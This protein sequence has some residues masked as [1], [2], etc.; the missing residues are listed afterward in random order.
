MVR[1][2]FEVND[3]TAKKWRYANPEIKQFIEK[4]VDGLL[5]LILEKELDT[6]W[7]LLKK[8]RLEAEQKGF[9][10]SILEQILNER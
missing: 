10:D 6:L 2:E 4:E 5:K 3:D 1:I 8:I 7:P 9:N